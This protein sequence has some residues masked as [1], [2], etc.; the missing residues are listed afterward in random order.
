MFVSG[1][2]C[3][4]PGIYYCSCATDGI[5]N[6]LTCET[7]PR[8]DQINIYTMQT[9][10]I[11]V[12][13]AIVEDITYSTLT[14]PNLFELY[15]I[16]NNRFICYNG[17]CMNEHG[18]DNKH[19]HED[20][21]TTNRIPGTTPNVRDDGTS[22]MEEQAQLVTHKFITTTT[23]NTVKTGANANNP[24]PT[25][26]V[27]KPKPEPTVLVTNSPPAIYTPP[28]TKVGERQEHAAY[29]NYTEMSTKQDVL[30]SIFANPPSL[31]A[32][33]QKTKASTKC[34]YYEIS[35]YV[36]IG[37]IFCLIIIIC[38]TC[39]KKKNYTYEPPMEM[40]QI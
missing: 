24:E 14:W 27:S 5:D 6:Y 20:I 22:N 39:K 28:T 12:L 18:L 26:L 25:V 19:D 7:F 15:D 36:S 17:R 8:T 1:R 30:Q 4:I 23:I 10:S 3:Q 9:V 29:L 33:D 16:N 40:N 38:V 37:L 21:S 2:Q 34:F 35:L 11:S 31:N 32:H 13:K